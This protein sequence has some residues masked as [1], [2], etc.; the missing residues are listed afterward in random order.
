LTLILDL[1]LLK[2]GVY[3]H[4][5]YNRGTEPRRVTAGDSPSSG[6][7]PPRKTAKQSKWMLSINIGV[8]LVTMD[9]FI[10]W[11]HLNSQQPHDVSPWNLETTHA[12]LRIFAGC[13][14][15][16]AGFHLGILLSCLLIMTPLGKW[17]ARKRGT[18]VSGIQAEF[19]YSLIP[20]TL[21]Y[22][23][24]TKLFLLFLLTIWRPTTTSTP[25]IPSSP[26]WL[27]NSYFQYALHLLDED[28]LSREWLVRNG[29]G[30][31]SAGFGL[32]GELLLIVIH[33]HRLQTK[34]STFRIMT[35][36]GFSGTRHPPILHLD[37]H[38]LR[39]VRQ[40]SRGDCCR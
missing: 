34:N 11:M 2:Q 19:R 24:L 10:R 33:K 15:E 4:L 18:S 20:L 25:P 31:L 23:S 7:S 14:A 17:R 30:G 40:N 13:L 38:L 26:S 35:V 28:F 3:R 6:H 37:D 12:F 39:L 8:A 32:R 21:L 22:S 1:I 16:T 9:A 27:T 29:L 36:S 5:L